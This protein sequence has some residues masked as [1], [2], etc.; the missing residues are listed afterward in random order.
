MSMNLNRAIVFTLRDQ[1]VGRTPSL[2]CARQSRCIRCLQMFLSGK[3]RPWARRTRRRI[4]LVP[5]LENGTLRP[6]TG[7]G[8]ELSEPPEAI[9]SLMKPERRGKTALLPTKSD[10]KRRKEELGRTNKT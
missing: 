7:K 2:R 10:V 1:S 4:A 3:A 9:R 5:R 6:V 8:F